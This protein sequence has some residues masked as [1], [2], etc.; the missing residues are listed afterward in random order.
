MYF[1]YHTHARRGEMQLDH[2]QFDMLC[3]SNVYPYAETLAARYE[4]EWDDVDK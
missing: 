4:V 1:V 2:E 3:A